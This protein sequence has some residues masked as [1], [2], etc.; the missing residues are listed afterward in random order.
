MRTTSDIK[1]PYSPLVIA[2]ASDADG[3]D[4]LAVAI[5]MQA[6][7][8][9]QL[10]ERTGRNFIGV[11]NKAALLSFFDSRWCSCL[12]QRTDY[13]P[14]WIKARLLRPRTAGTV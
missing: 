3:V 9:Y 1:C 5:I 2:D 12:L 8:D 6:V 10:L 7:R 4:M 14:D 13:D 11:E